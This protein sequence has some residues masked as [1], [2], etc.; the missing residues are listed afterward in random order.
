M[1]HGTKGSDP[2]RRQR[3]ADNSYATRF[4]CHPLVRDARTTRTTMTASI[5]AALC[6]FFMCLSAVLV[7]HSRANLLWMLAARAVCDTGLS[8]AALLWLKYHG[9]ERAAGC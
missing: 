5:W 1:E 3:T 7:R 2:A 8:T 9:R 4:A 6:A